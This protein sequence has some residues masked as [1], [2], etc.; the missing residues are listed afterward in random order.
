MS[1]AADAAAGPRASF[2]TPGGDGR[3][4]GA[5]AP[6]PSRRFE[7]VET[8]WGYILRSTEP[9]PAYVVVGQAVAAL[10]GCVLA[11]AAIALWLFGS[12]A[13]DGGILAIK[14]CAT[15]LMAALAG[16][17]LWF[18]TR[19]DRI[20]FQFDTSLGELREV[21]RNR[22]GRPTLS[23]RYGFDGLGRATF[24]PCRGRGDLGWLMLHDLD[25]TQSLTVVRAERAAIAPL[26]GRLSRDLAAGSRRAAQFDAVQP[27]VERRR[28]PRPA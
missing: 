8:Y 7:V 5:D 15:V 24:E 16:L 2:G 21:V 17:L 6:G 14:L 11:G 1:T 27:L 10:L 3:A 23:A 19:G 20:E 26:V 9:A 22:A 4:E 13:G 28:R 18:A 25:G 12:G